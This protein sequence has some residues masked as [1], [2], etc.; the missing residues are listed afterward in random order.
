MAWDDAAATDFDADDAFTVTQ[1]ANL[2]ERDESGVSLPFEWYFLEQASSGGGEQ[3]AVETTMYMP[4]TIGADV[5]LKGRLESKVDVGSN[6]QIW[7]R[8][9]GDDGTKAS[10]SQTAYSVPSNLTGPAMFA[11]DG[12][13]DLTVQIMY[14]R[15]LGSGSIYAQSILGITFYFEVT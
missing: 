7:I 13:T 2:V 4:A 6:G 9:D 3:V 12:S 1:A 14:E 8:V 10:I 11:A 15:T 5:V